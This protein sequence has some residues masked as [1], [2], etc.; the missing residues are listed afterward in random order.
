MNKERLLTDVV[1][2][3][4]GAE[5]APW[6]EA[7]G[8][9]SW[10]DHPA[11]WFEGRIREHELR[12]FARPPDPG[13]Y[14][15]SPPATARHRAP[16]VRVGAVHHGRT[17]APRRDSARTRS[18]PRMAVTTSTRPSVPSSDVDPPPRQPKSLSFRAGGVRG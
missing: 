10:D 7:G 8:D 6:H 15:Q 12:A 16:V 18:A 13:W 2:L 4:D 11:S 14:P 1:A 5:A 17:R 3:V 9:D